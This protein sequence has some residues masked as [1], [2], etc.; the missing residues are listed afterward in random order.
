MS[1]S[2]IY[3]FRIAYKR[4]IKRYKTDSEE[5]IFA[6]SFLVQLSLFHTEKSFDSTFNCL[7]EFYKNSYTHLKSKQENELQAAKDFTKA[8]H[9]D[10]EEADNWI[11]NV[12]YKN[13]INLREFI[14]QNQINFGLF[15]C[16]I[17]EQYELEQDLEYIHAIIDKL[18]DKETFEIVP[19]KEIRIKNAFQKGIGRLF[20]SDVKNGKSYDYYTN[21]TYFE[22]QGTR[23]IPCGSIIAED[24]NFECN[25]ERVENRGGLA[26][27]NSGVI[28]IKQTNSN[29]LEDIKNR[30]AEKYEIEDIVLPE[31]QVKDEVFEFI[32]GGALIINSGQS[33]SGSDLY[34]KQQ[35]VQMTGDNL[36][37]TNGFNSM[38][39]QNRVR[40]IMVA[41]YNEIAFLLIV[42]GAVKDIQKSLLNHGFS[43]LIT[44]DGSGGLFV[45]RNSVVDSNAKVGH[46]SPSGFAITVRDI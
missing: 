44:F 26:I 12:E 38:Q 13:E 25:Y 7:K 28:I 31:L 3:D 42:K 43:D 29:K 24:R 33:I 14:K 20:D 45:A 6:L 11:S 39:L 9:F 30:F 5:Y 27:L 19:I 23:Y 18:Y 41:K 16:K 22:A 21:G 2:W 35:F 10:K 46:V 15:D 4:L 34:S 32:G 8:S 1:N 17:N 40:R 36:N 37:S